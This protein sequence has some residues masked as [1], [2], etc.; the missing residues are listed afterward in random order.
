[1]LG[2]AD[3]VG[4]DIGDHRYFRR[5]DVG[6]GERFR[7]GV[8]GRL[9]QRAMERRGHG[10]QH[11]ALGA[12]AL[13]DLDGLVHRGLGAR[14][15]DLPAAVVVGDLAD[16]AGLG[17]RFRRDRDARL[18]VEAEQCRH[19]ALPNGYGGLHGL[20]TQAKQT[21]G[22]RQRKGAGG[23]ERGIFAERVAGDEFGV[24][25]EIEPGFGLQHAGRGEADGHQR[26]LGVGG[27]NEIDLGALEHQGR[28]LFAERG[29]DLIEHG[30]GGGETVCQGF[31]HAH[32]LRALPRKY[33]CL[34]HERLP[35]FGGVSGA[36]A[37]TSQVG[38]ASPGATIGSRFGGLRKRAPI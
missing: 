6:G 36:G 5:D 16:A 38:G 31:T 2:I 1:M 22:V 7:H 8:G 17:L 29:V 24:A 10:E 28:Q 4:H 20:S 12:L 34:G 27:Q 9:H 26:G 11:G 35:E 15:H 19:G 30:A 32:G 14:R 37:E 33:E 23:G 3:S 18:V 13:G 25:G 21:R